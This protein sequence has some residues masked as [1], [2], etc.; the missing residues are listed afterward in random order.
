MNDARIDAIRRV[1]GTKY[2]EFVDAGFKEFWMGHPQCHNKSD[3][4]LQKAIWRDDVRLFF[5]NVWCFDFAAHSSDHPFGMQP[6]VQFNTHSDQEPTINIDIIARDW[7]PQQVE[8]WFVAAYN[9]L[10]CKPYGD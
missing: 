2:L 9:K 4:L 7:T 5:V 8:E 10:G 6:E 1:G 3:Y